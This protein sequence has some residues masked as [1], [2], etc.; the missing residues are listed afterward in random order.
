MLVCFFNFDTAI[1]TKNQDKNFPML[2]NEEIM[3]Q[4]IFTDEN[5]GNKTI[6]KFQIWKESQKFDPEL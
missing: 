1:Q 6:L 4:T 5:D 3:N 2:F